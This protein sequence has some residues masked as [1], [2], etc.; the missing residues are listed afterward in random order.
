MACLTPQKKSINTSKIIPF[1]NKFF[2]L[3]SNPH[4]TNFFFLCD[5][6]QKKCG[7][8]GVEG[9]KFQVSTRLIKVCIYVNLLL[10]CHYCI[11]VLCT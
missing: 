5:I 7:N 9:S 8:F 1:Y 4:F 11:D 2:L 3:I 10:N 6:S